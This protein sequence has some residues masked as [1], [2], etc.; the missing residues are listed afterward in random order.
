MRNVL[1][2][3]KALADGAE[4]E[5]RDANGVT[6]LIAAAKSGSSEI[7]RLLLDSGANPHAADAEGITALMRASERGHLEIARQLLAKGAD[8]NITDALGRT[9]VDAALGRVAGRNTV[10]SEEI[11]ARLRAARGEPTA[12]R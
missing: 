6:P 4:V 2:A 3:G 7:V 11:A 10:V 8:P 9:P 1:G 5:S 12:A